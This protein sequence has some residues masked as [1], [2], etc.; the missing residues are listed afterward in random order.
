V[1]EGTVLA[2]F[3]ADYGNWQANGSAFGQ[4]PA[5]GTLANQQAVDGFRGKGLVNSYLNGD[6][7]R[8]TLTSAEFEIRQD[9]ISFLIG[10]G[11][12]PGRTGICLMIDGRTV[13]I[14]TGDNA[15]RL[16]WKS[17]NVREFSGSKARIEIF[18]QETG[19]WGHIN[20][21]HIVM[22]DKPASAKRHCG[23]IT[24]RISMQPF[25]GAIF[26]NATD[27]GYGLGG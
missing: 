16:S 13:R 6:Q 5:R 21:D 2:D 11:N 3:E 25:R 7:T 4:G 15:E 18:D 24:G 19:G 9:Y 17:W 1:P 20:V 23:R 10:G 26:R 22:A 14:A 27:G 8:G 12:H